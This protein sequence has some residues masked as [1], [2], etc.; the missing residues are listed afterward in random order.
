[1]QHTSVGSFLA[2]CHS[3]MTVAAP[4]ALSLVLAG[5]GAGSSGGQAIN[6]AAVSL[7]ASDVPR[8]F[9]REIARSWTNAQAA[10]RDRVAS[11]LYDAHGRISSYQ[12]AYIQQLAF[13][14]PP[15]G[16]L[17]RAASEVTEYKNAND[18]QWGWRQTV[19]LWRHA[20]QTGS[21]TLGTSSGQ[22]AIPVPF[23]PITVPRVGDA[24]SGFSATWGGDEAAYTGTVVVAREGR[25][26]IAVETI[27]YLDQVH[28]SLAVSLTRRI[29]QRIRKNA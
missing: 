6:L 27:G 22:A 29:V 12:D 28:T 21:T 4:V 9:A 16:G 3:L 18:A 13:H 10:A 23:K 20:N 26:V 5:C 15:A 14:E 24:A 11:S 1:M 17:H 7:R 8:G 25:Y 19:N 2:R